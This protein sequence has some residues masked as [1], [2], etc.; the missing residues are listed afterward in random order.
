MNFGA[1]IGISR[2]RS[3][4]TGAGAIDFGFGEIDR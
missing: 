3:L 2:T 4:C 1:A